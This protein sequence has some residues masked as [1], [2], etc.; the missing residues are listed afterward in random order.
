MNNNN[1]KKATGNY[2]NT[3][4]FCMKKLRSKTF[5]KKIF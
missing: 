5:T 1:K 2:R 3:T 4:H